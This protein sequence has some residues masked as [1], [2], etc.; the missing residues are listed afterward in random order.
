MSFLLISMVNTLGC[1]SINVDNIL[2][3]KKIFVLAL[4][5]ASDKSV[6]Q[7][8]A[9]PQEG[10]LWRSNS[11]YSAPKSKKRSRNEPTH[12]PQQ[13]GT[14]NAHASSVWR[15]KGTVCPRL[16][17]NS[18]SPRSPCGPGSSASTRLVSP[19]SPTNRAQGVQPLTHRHRSLQ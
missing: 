18:S 16:R 12:A 8:A 19:P 1:E 15:T 9:S 2:I 4:S 10:C 14:S 13:H 5:G 11:E 6:I 7:L 3:Y 17:S